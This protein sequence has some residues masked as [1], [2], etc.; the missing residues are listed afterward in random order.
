ME[1]SVCVLVQAASTHSR[2]SG[3]SDTQSR[4]IIPDSHEYFVSCHTGAG[5]VLRLITRFVDWLPNDTQVTWVG[6]SIERGSP[7]TAGERAGYP[8]D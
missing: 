2:S 7:M 3:R 1:V 4:G 6:A 8:F 5:C